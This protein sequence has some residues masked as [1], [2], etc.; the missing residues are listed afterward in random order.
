MGIFDL[1]KKK[2]GVNEETGQKFYDRILIKYFNGSRSKLGTDAKELLELTKYGITL[3]EMA[4]LL[5]RCLGTRELGGGWNKDVAYAMSRE[6][7]GKLPDI[8]FR[9]INYSS[10]STA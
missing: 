4:A 2:K 10:S 1:F 9:I 8:P 5:V 7:S 6:C 3:E